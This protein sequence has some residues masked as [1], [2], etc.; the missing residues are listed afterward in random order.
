MHSGL[1]SLDA[2]S[3]LILVLA[4]QR[5]DRSA[6]DQHVGQM[7]EL[8]IAEPDRFRA[9]QALAGNIADLPRHLRAGAVG[10]EGARGK[11]GDLRQRQPRLRRRGHSL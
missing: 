6:A 1:R 8:A 11:R 3:L 5:V 2:G 9:H 10:I 4:M 7:V